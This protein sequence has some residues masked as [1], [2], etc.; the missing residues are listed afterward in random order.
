MN[1]S[2]HPVNCRCDENA[3]KPAA[4]LTSVHL[5]LSYGGEGALGYARA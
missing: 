3:V 4:V 1:A 2:A 5:Q